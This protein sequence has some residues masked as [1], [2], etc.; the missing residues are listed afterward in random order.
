MGLNPP[1]TP[2][3]S[4]V[5]RTTTPDH[6]CYPAYSSLLYRLAKAPLQRSG[7]ELSTK[8]LP[9]NPFK[10]LLAAIAGNR[11]L[12]RARSFLG[13]G[14]TQLR[15]QPTSSSKIAARSKAS[16]AH[17]SDEFEKELRTSNAKL[18]GRHC[19]PRGERQDYSFQTP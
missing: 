13:F 16:A 4:A 6:L 10:S 12:G 9:S 5:S 19:P 11:C 1:P 18:A 7:F 8:P 2:L 3:S 17:A 15:L 14:L